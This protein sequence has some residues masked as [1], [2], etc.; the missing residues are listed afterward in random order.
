MGGRLF[1]Q[2]PHMQDLMSKEEH[3][4]TPQGL[5]QSKDVQGEKST[6]SHVLPKLLCQYM[7]HLRHWKWNIRIGHTSHNICWD[8]RRQ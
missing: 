5:Q 3:V 1:V 7:A 8:A 4:C 6:Q 2:P